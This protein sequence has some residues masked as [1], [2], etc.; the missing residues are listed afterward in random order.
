MTM[1]P[2]IFIWLGLA[3]IS[4]AIVVLLFN[5]QIGRAPFDAS[6]PADYQNLG[7]DFVLQGKDGAVAL[8]DYRGKVVV[9]YFGY[10][11]CPDICP[12]ALGN[13]A[14]VFKSLPPEALARVQGI[15]VSVDPER[16]TPEHL[17]QYT[18]FFHPQIVGLTGSH[19]VLQKIAQ[20]YGSYFKIQPPKIAGG[21]D[22]SVDHTGLIYVINPEGKI[23]QPISHNEP[24]AVIAQVV[25]RALSLKQP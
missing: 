20:Q 16:D 10:T 13:I 14:Q 12:T 19:A 15:F 24:E 6:A 8:K 11:F 2:R 4:A 7:G 25:K 9:L 23:I 21:K 18:A 17:A 1:N 22:Y 5:P 3:L